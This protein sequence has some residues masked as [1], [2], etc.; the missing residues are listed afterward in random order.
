MLIY[1]FLHLQRTREELKELAPELL[2]AFD[3]L[4]SSSSPVPATTVKSSTNAFEDED[5]SDI[6]VLESPA[7]VPKDSS[8]ENDFAIII[9]PRRHGKSTSK[10]ERR[11]REEEVEKAR[12]RKLKGKGKEI[13][14]LVIE[15]DEDEEESASGDDDAASFEEPESS[16]SVSESNEDSDG[17]AT[18]YNRRKKQKKARTEP[19]RK[20]SRA[21]RPQKKNFHR[22]S[23]AQESS[24]SDNEDFVRRTTRIINPTKST[25]RDATS[26]GNESSDEMALKTVVAR[27]KL[28]GSTKLADDKKKVG[29]GKSTEDSDAYEE[30]DED[31]LNSSSDETGLIQLE[32]RSVC[33][34]CGKGPADELIAKFNKRQSAKQAGRGRKRKRAI[35]EEDTD[36]E[37]ETLKGLGAWMECNVW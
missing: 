18:D 33:R 37:E 28:D 21:T 34:K 26:S 11:E 10:K 25:A 2:R 4:S 13:E 20:S 3:H 14:T 15:S 27:S 24:T 32:H 31:E 17:S 12:I 8:S 9:S 7:T 29:T 23:S 1:G 16:P 22:E 6:E 5:D 36:Q 19:T 30:N 35:D